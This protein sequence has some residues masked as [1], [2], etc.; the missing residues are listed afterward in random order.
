MRLSNE[1]RVI[2]RNGSPRFVAMDKTLRAR[3][4]KPPGEMPGWPS[5]GAGCGTSLR[6]SLRPP[7]DEARR[8]WRFRPGAT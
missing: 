6:A 3:E 8:S 2:T 4:A 7:A 5:D 1:S